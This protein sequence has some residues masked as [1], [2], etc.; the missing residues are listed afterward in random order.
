M[1]HSPPQFLATLP[2]HSDHECD[3]TVYRYDV[4]LYR[5]E[6]NACEDEGISRC[7]T[8]ANVYYGSSDEWAGKLCPRHFYEQHFGKD[9]ICR[10]I[11][12]DS[13]T[14]HE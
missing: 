13:Q 7:D 11:D 10:L 6:R 1:S 5:V 8:A 12:E 14:R 4:C 3:G 2:F 9:A